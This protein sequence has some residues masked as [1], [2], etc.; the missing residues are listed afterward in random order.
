MLT[1]MDSPLKTK[2]TLILVSLISA[3][4]IATAMNMPVS[5]YTLAGHDDALFWGRAWEMLNG[6]WLGPYDHMT[7]SKGPGFSIF[8]ALNAA[9]GI[10]ITLSISL[11]YLFGCYLFYQT[12]NLISSRHLINLLIFSVVLFIPEIFPTRIIRDNIYPAFSLIVVSGVFRICF[13]NEIKKYKA[14]AYGLCAGFF[15][16]IREEG[17][18]LVPGIV[19]MCVMF[20]LKYWI[21]N[22]VS[23][24]YSVLHRLIFFV[25]SAFIFVGTL[26]AINF[27]YY[28][29]YVLVDFKSHHF[30]ETL[31]LLNGIR[32]DSELSHV[33]VQ[34]SKRDLAYQVSPT[35]DTLRPFFEDEKNNWKLPGCNY[36]SWTCGDYAGGWFMWAFRDGVASLGHYKSARDAEA[37]YK[38]VFEEITV[39]CNSKKIQCNHH[40]L[41]FIPKLSKEQYQTIPA[42]LQDGFHI[43]MHKNLQYTSAGES[44]DPIDM[45]N[46]V[47]LF[48]R[49]PFTALS[50]SEN[51]S[52]IHGWYYE[53]ND[54][55]I[56][57][58]C[59]SDEQGI[60]RAPSR[61]IAN[62][63]DNSKAEYQRFSIPI[64]KDVECQIE[65]REASIST[66]EIIR[67]G[68]GSYKIGSGTFYVENVGTPSGNNIRNL[69]LRLKNKIAWLY[70]NA[71]SLTFYIGLFCYAAHTLLLISRKVRL[72]PAY[73]LCTAL[74]VSVL[75]RLLILTLVDVSSFPAVNSLYLGPAFTMFYSAIAISILLIFDWLTY[76]RSIQD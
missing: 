65:N 71:I 59:E 9:S 44:M 38:K 49:N 63:F 11:L 51:V 16:S 50:P 30:S 42:K 20:L 26:M 3:L 5:I 70:G 40:I 56:R 19:V 34:K 68:G 7:L 53:N 57:L 73:I 24:I 75:A 60:A 76:R 31:K 37:F 28:K 29:S 32:V 61:D 46:N 23:R 17:V 14:I 74:C 41:P 1:N 6:N 8:L 4:Y 48:L 64:R 55:W 22:D 15:W 45:L 58:K 18:W 33:P 47:R 67:G 69:S 27:H 72:S 62:A 21:E 13:C 43:L 25:I 10:P 52:K 12:L 36:Y 2:Y 66:S 54:E 35:F 39:A